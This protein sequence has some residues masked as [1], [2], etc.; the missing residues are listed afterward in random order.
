MVLDKI[1]IE[2]LLIR[3]ILGINTEE[4]IHKQDISISV[5]LFADLSAASLS[6]D[7]NDTINYKKLKLDIIDLAENSQFFLIEKM[8]QEIANLIL[9]DKRVQKC[10][11]RLEKPTALRFCKTVA[12]EIEREQPCL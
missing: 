5:T 9:T 11:V 7:I 8:V 6:D 12:V 10:I 3:V 1:M 2:D 4:R